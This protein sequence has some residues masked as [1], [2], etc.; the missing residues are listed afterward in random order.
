MEFETVIGL[1]VHV[2]LGTASKVFCSCPTTF[3]AKPNT[4]VCPICVGLPGVLPVLNQA[5]LEAAVKVG[6]ALN[7]QIAPYS[8]FDRKNYTYPDLPKSYQISQYDLPIAYSGYVDV[9]AGEKTRRIGIRRVHL[10]EDAGK[11]VHLGT[12]AEATSSLVDFNRA[13]VP[14]LEIV[15]EPD[16]RSVDEARAY[17]EKLKAIVQY[18]GVSEVRMERGHLRCDVNVSLRPAGSTE[19]GTRSEIKNVNSFRAAIRGMEYEIK[20]QKEILEK[21]GKVA[22][23]T[24]A[25]DDARGITV[26]LRT[27]EEAEDYRYFPEPDLVPVVLDAQ[28][29]EELRASLPELPDARR[30]R[31]VEMG[32]S[33]YDA[34]VITSSRPMADFFD[35]AAAETGQPKTVANWIMG[36]LFRLLNAKGLEPEDNPIRAENLAQM[37]MLLDKGTISGKIAKTVFEEMFET[38]KDP[39]TIVKEKGLVQITDES[40]IARLAEEVIRANPQVAADY[41]SGKERASGFLVGQLMK[42]SRGRANP[43]LANRII[44]EKLEELRGSLG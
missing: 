34:G 10:E 41:Y 30:K 19:L 20:R 37:I 15:S 5:A 32:L 1:E 33:E 12:V 44:R 36:E 23:E 38:G 25:W 3:G 16:L 42:A 18:T 24:R 21:G 14:L 31:L 9:T 28:R 22:Q 11:L 39:E 8:K 40:E 7:C 6:L 43:D 26:V 29:I 27:K 13:G 17:L 2:E 35:R 4:Q